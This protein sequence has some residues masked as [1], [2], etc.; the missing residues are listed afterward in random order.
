[1]AR[2]KIDITGHVYGRWTVL[3]FSRKKKLDYLWN[4]RCE[5]GTEREVSSHSMRRGESKSC[6]C[7]SKE[8][9]L[10]IM[11]LSGQVFDRL[12]VLGLSHRIINK[13]VYW[14]CL[15]SCGKKYCTTTSSLRSGRCKSCGC[16]Q[17]E[18]AGNVFRTHGLS[19]TKMYKAWH[20]MIQRCTNPNSLDYPNYGGRGITV[21]PEWY[22]Y[23]TFYND[24]GDRPNGMTLDRIDVNG[25][26]EPNNCR[27]ITN[28]A[29]QNNRRDNVL[30]SYLNEVKT[31][32]EWSRYFNIPVTNIR[33][34]LNRGWSL[35][36]V[37]SKEDFTN[38]KHPKHRKR[39]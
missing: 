8:L 23:L 25:N 4:C 34:R 15:C 18:H 31:I 22:D 32:S 20:G 26:Y 17:R 5:C 7:I 33:N 16:L 29:Q 9:N 6:G 12:T 27:W 11:D 2:K 37:F 36:E 35:D 24:M 13:A 21:C 10:E 28:L 3:S 38:K 39:K 1:M 14:N 19:Q 30:I